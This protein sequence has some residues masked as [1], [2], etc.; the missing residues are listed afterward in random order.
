MEDIHAQQAKDLDKAATAAIGENWPLA[1]ALC[2]RAEKE[3][4]RKRN[5]TAAL[6]R[7]DAIDP[8]DAG[9]S[10]LKS[11]AACEDASAFSGTCAQLARQLRS[12][13]ENHT[14]HWWNLL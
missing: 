4:T 13:P 5:L 8:I 2:A 12:L 3:W 14:F 6:Y 9:F 1:N 7:H 10:A 11:Y